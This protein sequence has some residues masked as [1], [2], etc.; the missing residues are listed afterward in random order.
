[1]P[2]LVLAALIAAVCPPDLDTDR[3]ARYFAEAKELSELDDGA[4][5]GHALYERLIFVDTASG[6][7]VA[8]RADPAGELTRQ[9]EVWVGPIPDAIGAAN[10]AQSWQGELWTTVIWPLI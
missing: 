7:I 3:A 10:T 6:Q 2:S 1:M 5:W 8:N 9:G 4:L